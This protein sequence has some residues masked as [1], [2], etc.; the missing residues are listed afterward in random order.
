[1]ARMVG[2]IAFALGIGMAAVAPVV[3][4]A[5]PDDDAGTPGASAAQDPGGSHAERGTR[6]RIRAADRA[7]A[8]QG[9]AP[10]ASRR[11]A[12]RAFAEPAPDNTAGDNTAGDN[13]ADVTTAQGARAQAR[14]GQPQRTPMPGAVVPAPVAPA[15]ST[16]TPVEP[17]MQSVPVERAEPVQRTDAP[18]SPRLAQSPQRAAVLPAPSASVPMP[19]VAA[20]RDTVAS[21]TP[22][23][24]TLQ[25]VIA[26]LFGG[27]PAA[28]M[29]TPMSWS[30]LAAARRQYGTVTTA[31]APAATV[32]TGQTR[33]AVPL[34]AAT[35][36]PPAVTAVAVGVPNAATGA[37]TGT[38]TAVDADNDPLTYRA[39]T[40]TKGTVTITSG[41]VFTYTPT[42]TARHAA[43]KVNATTSATTDVV[44]IVVTD[45]KGATAARSVTVPVS[46]QNAIP[47]AKATV[48]TPTTTSGAIAGSVTATD[49]DKD[50][51]TY[52]APTSTAK[53]SV[54]FNPTTATFTYTP[55]AAARNVAA[56]AY[57]TTA[58]KTDTFTVTITDGYGASVA[59]PVNVAVSPKSYVKFN[60]NYLT[61]SQYWTPESRSALEL[62]AT[63]V[64]SYL[65]VPAPV[66]IVYDVSADSAPTSTNLAWARSDFTSTSSGFYSTVVQKKIITGV[67]ANG[68]AAD[69]VVSV[70]LGKPWSFGSSVSASQYDFTSTMMHEFVHTLGFISLTD[71]AGK[72]TGTIWT[73]FDRFLVTS[74]KA[75]V[76][77][78]TYRWNTAY[79]MNLTGVNG[80][81]YFGGPNAVAAYGGPVPLFAPS[82]WAYG[83]S[84]HH[85]R[86][87]SFYGA[88]KKLMN[89]QVLLGPGVRVLSPVE[90]G[91]LKDLGYG[92]VPVPVSAA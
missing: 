11:A 59:V 67:D 9:S 85:L 3:A 5:A 16:A 87:S 14:N 57:A 54:I 21:A 63:K 32:S 48:G 34:P 52:S 86:D 36:R 26:E 81:L 88:Q 42:P 90:L 25:T 56:G 12:G 6:V 27:N 20:Q 23:G 50:P 30:V 37:V 72:N 47:V 38:V 17:T 1:M 10:S 45:T 4:W 70:N 65:V 83:S 73:Q 44:S 7:A 51:L 41:G 13:A 82:P 89:A 75:P 77:D 35:N 55:T 64:A 60:F 39:T 43:A 29:G 58:D 46:P 24:P 78:S 80:G 49:A 2:T 22:A 92:V 28:P 53:G 68:S 33:Q 18:A 71:Q 69:G 84:V 19:A 91:I 8:P 76:I 74:T 31:V 61:G 40:S 62:A 79:D 15:A 66:T